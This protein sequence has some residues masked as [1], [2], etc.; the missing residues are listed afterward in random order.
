MLIMRSIWRNMRLASILKS[1]NNT[2][3]WVKQQTMKT[4]KYILLS[5][6]LIFGFVS[7]AQVTTTFHD[8]G[9]GAATRKTVTN[10]SEGVYTIKLE[11]F[12][13]GTS[14]Y[15]SSYV[16]VD[17]L[18]VL[19]VSTSMTQNNYPVGSSTTRLAALK[20]AV[21]VFI[22]SIY[23]NAYA[24]KQTDASF[25]GNRIGI[26]SFGG[27]SRDDTD[28]WVNVL[29]NNAVIKNGDDYSGSLITTVTNLSTGSSG[30]W[31]HSGIELGI[32]NYLDGAPASASSREDAS[33]VVVIFT[34]GEPAAG[35]DSVGGQSGPNFNSYIAN[36]AVFLSNQLK[37]EYGATVFTVTLLGNSIDNRVIP[38]ANLLSSN[39]PEATA[40]KQSTN[41]WTYHSDTGKV[42]ASG[43]DYGNVEQTGYFQNV[44]A[45]NL[46]SIFQSIAD[47]SGASSASVGTSTQVRDVVSSSFTVP[48]GFDASDVTLYTLNIKEDG[49]GWDE[50][51]K[52]TNPTGVSVTPG[53]NSD[54]N[55]TL[56]VEGFDFSKDDSPNQAGEDQT[57]D[58]NWVG[59]RYRANGD[60]FYAGKELVIEFDI[61]LKDDVTGGDATATNMPESGV[62]IYDEETEE[63]TCINNFLVPVRDLPVNITI[64]KTGLKY[65]ES[66][67]FEIHRA[68]PKK[69]SDGN[70][71]YNT[72][73]GKPEPD[74]AT[75]DDHFSKVI[76]TNKAEG[77]NTTTKITKT[78]LALDPGYVYR[79]VED[80]W[81]WAYDLTHTGNG[82]M[83]TSS[84]VVNPFKFT[85]KEKT[86]VV[87]HAE[88]VTINHFA[89][90]AGGTARE[91]HYK[92][93]KVSY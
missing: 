67:T 41:T 80:K 90:E 70:I 63:Y 26:V 4:L 50:T 33:L 93:A 13:T 76:V 74:P 58:G 59:I 22:G 6:S 83:T 21:K 46:N 66:A 25:T 16:P 75:W 28:G 79:V 87:K 20:D 29:E 3:Y 88:A 69:D 19:D 64:E 73:T 42:T 1:N 77:G 36:T 53:T 71:V 23:D 32:D 43:L 82:E 48:D 35:G 8:E 44:G 30:T 84:V 60:P 56:T 2:I 47:A 7:Y 10:K 5:V 18:L 81:G 15:V 37:T 9:K 85:N 86:G 61:E 78:I 34:D 39:Y 38:F 11:T 49:T 62:Y 17:I 14:S 45:S 52:V 40:E 68:L 54:G 27:F 12:A 24:A 72:I 89:T 65:G 57:G 55:K 92:S 31:T 51:T 91:E